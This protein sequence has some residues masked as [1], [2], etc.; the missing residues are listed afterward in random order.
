MFKHYFE[1]I[2]GIANYPVFSLTVFFI[3]FIS[4]TFWVFKA[5]K[6]Y[7]KHVENLPLK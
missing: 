5:D 3:F 1:G 4:L 2:A 6:D 7:I